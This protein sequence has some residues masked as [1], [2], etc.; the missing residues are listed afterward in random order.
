MFSGTIFRLRPRVELMEE[1]T[2]LSTFLV[3]NTGDSGAGSLRQSI[4]ESNAATGATNTI[5][6]NISGSGVQTIMPLSSLPAITNPVLIDG[7]SQPGYSGLPL[8]EINGSQA[9]GGD[10]LD[11]TAPHVTV[12]GLDVN[13]FSQGAGLHITGTDATGD[14]I[15]GN[16]LGTDP[17]GTQ[18]EP[19]NVGVEIDGGAANNLI[20]T[21]GDGTNDAAEQNVISGNQFVGVW[22]NGQGTK[23]NAVAGNLI[24]TSVTGDIAMDNGTS[25]ASY[26][27]ANPGSTETLI[28][29]GVV[30]EGGASSNRIGT[31]GQGV[32]DAGE[33][34]VIAGSDNDGIDIVGTGTDANLV[35][36][37]YIGTDLTGTIPLGVSTYDVHLAFGASGNYIGVNPD[38]GAMMSDEGNVISAAGNDGVMVDIGADNNVIAGNRVGTDATGE[39]A[40][41][42][43][44]VGIWVFS[45]SG[46][47]IGGTG[48]GAANVISGNG[49]SDLSYE[50][51]SGIELQSASGT[52]IEGNLIGTDATGTKALGNLG[53]GVDIEGYSPSIDN[54]VGGTSA[55]AGNLITD[56]GGP[57]VAVTGNAAV[58][59]QITSNR[60]FG[61]AGQAIDL[62][63]DGVTENGTAPRQ[64]PNNLQNFPL[65]VTTLGG[66]NEG[67]LGGSQPDTTY[68]IDIFASAGYGPGGAGRLKII[69]GRWS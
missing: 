6:F 25:P 53:D 13:S 19:N 27:P 38:G 5:D 18:P 21:N 69:W 32:D 35:A 55:I 31:D 33:R 1:R 68:R 56:N 67:W 58:G 52:L 43:D 46:N 60:I 62:G 11:I 28:G 29:G 14:W 26:P 50:T 15:Y 57:G 51:N 54:T 61:N 39:V 63:D 65:I 8:I 59:N 10:G 40:L 42:N 30:I 34:N 48:A 44:I 49:A 16:L 12:R 20:G 66:Q 22:I 9:G 3:N 47:T 37:N 23:S 41:G 24:G 4:L 17:S 7:E 64:G 2:L 36:G 45:N